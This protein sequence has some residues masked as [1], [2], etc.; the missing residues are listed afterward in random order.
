MTRGPSMAWNDGNARVS[1]AVSVV[2]LLLATGRTSAEIRTVLNLRYP[3][4]GVTHVT[5][6]WG[7]VYGNPV[8]FAG[9]VDGDGFDD[10]LIRDPD[11]NHGYSPGTILVYGQAQT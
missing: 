10:F 4:N 5:V 7:E 6:D 11:P 2:A 1:A 8:A 9:D 3:A